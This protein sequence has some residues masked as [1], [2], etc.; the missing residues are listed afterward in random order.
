MTTLDRYTIGEF[1]QLNH[2]Q[3]KL[4]ENL[5][6]VF[7][8]YVMPACSLTHTYGNQHNVPFKKATEHTG[9]KSKM[10]AMTNRISKTIKDTDDKILLDLRRAFS[11][12]V[13]GKDGTINCVNTINQQMIA[14][15]MV[16]K[17]ATLFY[18]TM[19]RSAPKI[20]EQYVDVLFSLKRHDN[21]QE[22][23]QVSFVKQV[24]QNFN[25]PPTIP[26]SKI[27]SG[28]ELTKNHRIATCNILTHLFAYNFSK[29]PNLNLEGPKKIF[30]DAEK[31]NTKYI[32]KL[33][34]LINADG[35]ELEI[36]HYNIRSLSEAVEILQKKFP[37]IVSDNSAALTEIYKN[38]KFK[39]TQRMSL[40]NFAN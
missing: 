5:K 1:E 4:P 36:A 25:S 6:T 17:I 3:V 38:K 19:T 31:A 39:L 8:A 14:P 30:D 27:S 20:I 26:A 15:K 11:S 32:R 2:G 21:L 23:I 18:E 29:N 16:D 37:Q 35:T 28:E 34:D 10:T 12:V 13:S 24:F 33:L 7:G 9:Y 40:R 22:K